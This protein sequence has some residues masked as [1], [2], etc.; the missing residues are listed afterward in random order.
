MAKVFIDANVLVSV[1]NKEYP[2]FLYSSR[3]LSLA[4]SREFQLFTSPLCLAI[5]FYF[6]S[7]K[8]GELEAKR[9]IK[10]LVEHISIAQITSGA[11]ERALANPKIN[12]LEDGFQYYAA[13]DAG[14]VC[15]VTENASDYYFSDKEIL[16]SESFLIKYAI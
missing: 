9:K 1:L 4:N 3:L 16:C 15:I 8:C 10:L 12:D 11:V 14:C 2:L 5:A 7:K 13:D 6:A